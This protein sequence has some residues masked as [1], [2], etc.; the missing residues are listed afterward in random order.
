LQLR[1][2]QPAFFL[3]LTSEADAARATVEQLEEAISRAEAKVRG[4]ALDGLQEVD[5]SGLK[6]TQG[7]APVLRD[8]AAADKAAK[9]AATAAR[10]AA[11]E[12]AEEQKQATQIVRDLKLQS[13]GDE[14]RA[15]A[16]LQDQ[17]VDL[18]KAVEL[19]V[20]S[21]QEAADI[22]AGL[23]EQWQ[24]SATDSIRIEL[25]TE[26]QRAVEDLQAK[27]ISLQN[28]IASGAITPEVGAERAAGLAE[29]WAA[30][31]QDLHDQ[32]LESL[33]AGLLTEE[34]MIA[35]SYEKRR[36]AIL[37]A[38]QLTEDEK[39][40]LLVRAEEE[41]SQAV[42][43]LERAHLNDRLDQTA[44]YLSAVSTLMDSGN[45]TL[46]KIGKAAAL[47]EATVKGYQAIQN[48]LA[49]V[50]Y[51]LNIAAAAAMAAATAVQIA[52]IASTNY[53]GGHDLGGDI[54]AGKYGLVGEHGPELV[55]G[56]VTV[57]G[58]AKTA[59]LLE[60]AASDAGNGPRLRQIIVF[61][62]D[63]IEGAMGSD[64]GERVF[65]TH[66]TRNRAKLRQILG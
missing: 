21:Q 31:Q 54:A 24:K 51:P 6:K 44:Y 13:L 60:R 35:A 4:R 49:E 20:V 47:A 52:N 11:R 14:A 40:D 17:Y 10:K 27:Y 63:A 55:S 9:E 48:A 32:Q 38:M 2:A 65:I 8:T 3:G 46:F 1:E 53:T 23:A 66:A 41:R 5:L 42:A 33:S 12:L 26:E 39:T 62:D 43:D 50:P 59:S 30:E 19:G 18:N 57:T 56:P 15:V 22:A 64:T 29:K 28:Q 61:G 34:E 36:E 45:S 25:L 7:P 16:A 37:E 58:R